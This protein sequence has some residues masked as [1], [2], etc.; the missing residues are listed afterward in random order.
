MIR[1]RF[2]LTKSKYSFQIT[3]RQEITRIDV[4]VYYYYNNHKNQKQIANRQ[5]IYL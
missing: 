1:I 4:L 3:M 5:R 2:D